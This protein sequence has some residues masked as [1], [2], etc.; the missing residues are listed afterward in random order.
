MQWGHKALKNVC[1]FVKKHWKTKVIEK[2]AI[3]KA[4]VSFKQKLKLM[5]SSGL[6]QKQYVEYKTFWRRKTN[7][8]GQWT[9]EQECERLFFSRKELYVGCQPYLRMYDIGGSF[10]C[11]E[12]KME[13]IGKDI[14]YMLV[15]QP[16]LAES[17]FNYQLVLKDNLGKLGEESEFESRLV[18]VFLRFKK[19]RS[20]LIPKPRKT[21]QSQVIDRYLYDNKT[22][23]VNE[24]E[25]VDLMKNLFE[26][27]RLQ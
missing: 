12:A 13:T 16:G 27:N 19:N 6:L 3:I 21:I 5:W 23:K 10:D 2:D 7:Y 24:N 9:L 4:F 15:N 22:Q 20:P 1:D 8:K 26:E 18:N 11:I 25:L 14:K 17:Q